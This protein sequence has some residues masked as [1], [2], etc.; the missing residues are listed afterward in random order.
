MNTLDLWNSIHF[1]KNETEPN[2]S[3]DT[4]IGM[5]FEKTVQDDPKLIFL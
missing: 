2:F 3:A 1:P 4:F 5:I